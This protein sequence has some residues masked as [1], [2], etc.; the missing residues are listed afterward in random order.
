M[1]VAFGIRPSSCV[2]TNTE[3]C[4]AVTVNFWCLVQMAPLRRT[5]ARFVLNYT[6]ICRS[7]K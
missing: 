1:R 7:F 5:V 2:R 3:R 6:I 4:S